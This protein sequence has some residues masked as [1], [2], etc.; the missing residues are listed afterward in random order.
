M[1]LVS[2]FQ[3]IQNADSKSSFL[4]QSY[5]QV[6][7]KQKMTFITQQNTGPAT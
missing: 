2:T 3:L 1:N 6:P 4:V 5:F 7:L